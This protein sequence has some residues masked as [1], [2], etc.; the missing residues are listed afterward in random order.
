MIAPSSALATEST[1]AMTLTSP[2][3]APISRS[4]AKRSSRRAAASRVAVLIRIS[5]GNR[6]A[7]T[8]TPN[9]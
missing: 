3:V 5:T 7:S 6:T 9:A 1:E 8:P 2:G 4:A